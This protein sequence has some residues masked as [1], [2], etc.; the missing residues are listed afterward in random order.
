MATN[1]GMPL[2]GH[3]FLKSPDATLEELLPGMVGVVGVPW[4]GTKISRLGA[5]G[6]PQAIRESTF[7][8]SFLLDSTA[9]GMVDLDKD[10][11]IT[12]PDETRLVDLGNVVAVPTD[13]DGTIT[14]VSDT[15]S[16]IVQRG[17]FPVV[18]GGDHF[19]AYP[20]MRGFSQGARATNPDVKLG[21]VHVDMHL[22]LTDH[23]PYWGKYHSGSPARRIAELDGMQSEKMVFFGVNGPQ[24]S[25]DFEFIKKSGVNVITMSAIKRNGIKDMTKRVQDLLSDCDRIYVSIDIDVLDR[26]VAPGTGNAVTIGGMVSDELM[27]F[28]EFIRE[29]P[30]GAV[31]LMELAPRWDPTG[32][33]QALGSAALIEIISP[34]I[35]NISKAGID[36]VEPPHRLIR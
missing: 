31:D 3:T 1:L 24:P 29:L 36:E 21:Y 26:S 27:Y 30:L 25:D 6:G 17:G 20:S 8:F 15:V 23:V 22:D 33:T 5:S 12:R 10:I 19:I 14:R 32:R 35:F 13:V 2:E 16:G 28:A 34:R 11:R 7:V 9:G 4:E 18:L